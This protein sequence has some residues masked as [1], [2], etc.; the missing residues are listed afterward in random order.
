MHRRH[1]RGLLKA[2][3]RQLVLAR[4]RPGMLVDLAD[5]LF[6]RSSGHIGSFITL[7][8]RGCHRAIR[9]GQETLTADLLDQ[10]RIDEAS[11]QARH[12]LSAAVTGG[13]LTTTT[14]PRRTTRAAAS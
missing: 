7:V 14:R 13:R 4:A 1:W 6:A 8:T 9:T 10:V 5:Y 2:T 3:E 11:E 12:H